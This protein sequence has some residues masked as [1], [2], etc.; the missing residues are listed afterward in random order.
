MII[1]CFIN[2]SGSL[3][4]YINKIVNRGIFSGFTI[5]GDNDFRG[6]ILR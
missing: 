1:S 2:F 5:L 6:I 4:V 3:D